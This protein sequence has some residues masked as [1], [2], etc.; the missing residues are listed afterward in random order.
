M[1]KTRYRV[2]TVPD[3]PEKLS[4]QLEKICEEGR[5]VVSIIWQPARSVVTKYGESTDISSGYVVVSER[6]F[7]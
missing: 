1:G 4:A 6:D 5:K 2:D 3:Q 7:A